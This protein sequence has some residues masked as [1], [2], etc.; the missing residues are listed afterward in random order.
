MMLER[1]IYRILDAGRQHINDNPDFIVEYFCDQGLSENE[2]RSIR[3]YWLRQ[4]RFFRRTL[5]NENFESVGGVNIVHQYPRNSEQPQFPCWAIVL[6]NE[7]EGGDKERF[8]GDEIDD[9]FDDE[10]GLLSFGGSIEQKQYA[11][12]VYAENPDVCIYYYELL[13]FFMKRARD[14]FKETEDDGGGRV[15]DTHFSGN[16]MGPDPRYQPE[17]MFIRR[18]GIEMKVLEA[19]RKSAQEE[20]GSRLGGAFVRNPD[21][22]DVTTEG[23]GENISPGVTPIGGSDE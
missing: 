19:I 22:L 2:A 16:D 17:Y 8:L 21:G 4:N 15:L 23:E 9:V 3:D 12:Y 7:R 20:R 6:E 11:I 13:T 10:E 18:L 5:D 14:V 1:L